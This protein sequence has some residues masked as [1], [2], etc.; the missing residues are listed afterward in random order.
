MLILSGM[1][2]RQRKRERIKLW[3]P[4][5]MTGLELLHATYVQQTFPRHAHDGFAVGV[6]EQGALGFYYRGENVVADAGAINL[7]NPG[8]VHTGHAQA[9]SGWTYRMFYMP[10]ETLQ[11]A[12]DELAQRPA[13]FP[14]FE[15]GVIQDQPLAR[16]IH[17][18]HRAL[19]TDGLSRLEKDSR[20]LDML[21][22]LIGRHADAPPAP[23]RQ[24]NAAR[25]IYRA[26]D[27][28]GTCFGED[29]SLR[30]LSDTACL[31]PFH[32]AREFKKETGLPPHAYLIQTRVK[33]AR[34]MIA[35]GK[36]IAQ[37]ACET[38][39]T[40]Q[41]HLTRHFKRITGVTPGQYRKIVQDP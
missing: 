2:R 4:P 1:Q 29:V 34:E 24:I 33:K 21:T 22:D 11:A 19:E 26:R 14:F 13:D 37:A 18:L 5:G 27:Y 16:K 25:E 12:A 9:D 28:I 31:S 30:G 6:I 39:F 7:A 17:A 10:A 32:F 36:Q 35:A 8:E 40:D 20:F 41:S 3:K 15:K 38:G 23:P